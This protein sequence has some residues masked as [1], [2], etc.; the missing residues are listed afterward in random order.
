MNGA[1]E[2]GGKYSG[3]SQTIEQGK[4]QEGSY[5]HDTENAI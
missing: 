4:K 1:P 2:E 3:R 5:R